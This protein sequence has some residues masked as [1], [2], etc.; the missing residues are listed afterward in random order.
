MRYNNKID[1]TKGIAEWSDDGTSFIIYD[2]EKFSKL[3]PKYFKTDNFASFVRQ[4][5]MYKFQ[6]VKNSKGYQQFSHQL[7]KRDCFSDLTKI[8]RKTANNCKFNRHIS[9]KKNSN[10]ESNSKV[11]DRITRLEKTL[12]LLT[13]QNQMLLKSNQKMFTNLT[14]NKIATDS[15]IK[16]LLLITYNA[17]KSNRNRQGGFNPFLIRLQNSIK[18]LKHNVDEEHAELTKSLAPEEILKNN[19]NETIL[20]ETLDFMYTESFKIATPSPPPH[21]M[22]NDEAEERL[23][24]QIIGNDIPDTPL[25]AGILTNGISNIESREQGFVIHDG[26][27]NNFIDYGHLLRRDSDF[28]VDD[29][30]ILNNRFSPNMIKPYS[31]DM[32]MYGR[33]ILK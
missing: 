20:N 32:N 16:K 31:I 3:L 17:T 26:P 9:K 12:K 15:K 10:A 25:N 21:K 27:I 30:A 33:N 19:Q 22:I 24:N 5:N 23:L 11:N 18:K 29:L 1:E 2:V 6:K 13:V 4:L 7:F 28:G 14:E 8:K